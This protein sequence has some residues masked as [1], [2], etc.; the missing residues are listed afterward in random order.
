MQQ[1][2]KPY[3]GAGERAPKGVH[4]GQYAA[5]PDGEVVLF[6]IGMRINRWRR[7]RSWW[8]VF[9]AMP[10]MIR[11]LADHP[12]AGL[13]APPRTYWSGRDFLVVQYWR[14]V[15]ELGAYARNSAFLHAAAWG[16][17]NRSGAATG[18]VG[19]WHETYTVRAEQIESLYGN[20]PLAGL[21][22]A[23]SWAPRL[24]RRPSR[25]GER[26]GQVA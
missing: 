1:M 22:A 8:P 15:E 13:L 12:E 24:R 18:D 10:R 11:E 2:P 5:T 19:I 16:A 26:M 17:F 25:A 20:M 23:T 6:L 7:V 3:V 21:A 4:G 14:S 9:T